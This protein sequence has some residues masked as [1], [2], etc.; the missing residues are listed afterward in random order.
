MQDVFV[1]ELFYKIR[2]V[3]DDLEGVKAVFQ[4]GMSPMASH[5]TAVK[6]KATS[7]RFAK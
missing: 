4:V 7:L 6:V 3:C 5:G 2:G 1:E